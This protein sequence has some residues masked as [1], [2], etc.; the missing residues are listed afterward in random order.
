[1]AAYG[2]VGFVE[3][4]A[5]GLKT[6]RARRKTI[7]H[8]S[9]LDDRLLADIGIERSRIGTAVEGILRAAEAGAAA[10]AA[11]RITDGAGPPA[12]NDNGPEGER[13]RAIE[14]GG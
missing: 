2:I 14:T 12:A 4:W 13:L 11:H 9:A 10:S 6:A 8:L 5:A 1:V 7:A 3:R